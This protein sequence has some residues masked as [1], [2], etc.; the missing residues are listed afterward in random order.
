MNALLTTDERAFFSLVHQA[1][2][3]NPF[4]EA[5]TALD[6]KIAG[7]YG[8]K[9]SQ[10]SVLE[11]IAE[12]GQSISQLEKKG[13][14]R[15]GHYR[16]KDRDLI[17]YAFL[18]DVFHRFIP[19]F[20]RLIADQLK[21]DDRNLEVPFAR[22]ALNLM[23]RR[24]FP[25]RDARRYFELFFQ[26]RRAF[27][28]I[29][30]NIVGCSPCMVKLREQLWN[31]IFTHDIDLYGRY[32]WN[33]MEDF[34]TLILGATG[35]GKG[36]SAMAIGRSGYIPFDEKKGCFVESF[37]RA[38]LSII[39][40]QYSETLI[41]SEL[42]GHK[43][44][45]FTGA[46]DNYQGVLDRCSPYG[47]ILLDEIGEVSE[48]LQI[49]LLQV[50]QER[51]FM[52]VGGHK[53]RRFSGRVIAATNRPLD[54]IRQQRILR[55]DFYYRLCS[56]VI[57]VPTLAQRI[58]EDRRE[59]TG[60]LAHTVTRILGRPSAE[61]TAMLE[62]IIEKQPGPD[63]TWPGNVRELEQCVRRLLIH[64][65]YE[66]PTQPEADKL[67][68]RLSRRVAHGDMSAQQ[69]ISEYCY[70]LY[71]RLGTFEAVAKAARLDRRTAKKYIEQGGRCESE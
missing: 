61:L 50:L 13:C 7:R 1:V 10:H 32:M 47:S 6:L 65:R 21:V 63:Y 45:A 43:K 60:L 12:V 15:I 71:Q 27:Y 5:R 20:D 70:M 42:F 57:I 33:R 56:D 24:G 64:Q 41:E 51:T 16:G 26:M 67:E 48:S 31:N 59:L 54:Q 25:A 69:L 36:T 35:A 11:T 17:R 53:A 52:P 8:Q 18:F 9:P 4:S 62:S 40:S 2:V 14:A 38:F 68:T 44:G 23:R 30:Q 66:A 55:D 34:S 3:A 28:F 49:K 39:L 29:Q 22:D 58:A 46:I 19:S 37:N